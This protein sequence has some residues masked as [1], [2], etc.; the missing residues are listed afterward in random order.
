MGSDLLRFWASFTDIHQKPLHSLCLP[1]LWCRTF[2][3]V[4]YE[5]SKMKFYFKK[6]NVLKNQAMN[7]CAI[8]IQRREKK[9]TDDKYLV[10]YGTKK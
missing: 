10:L 1:R 6:G 8:L 4:K 3:F 2:T 5:F 9:D 7:Y